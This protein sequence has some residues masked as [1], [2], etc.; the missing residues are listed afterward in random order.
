MECFDPVVIYIDEGD[1]AQALDYKVTR[2]VE[3][4]CPWVVIHSPEKSFERD[5]VMQVFAGMDSIAEI[6]AAFIENIENW[7]PASS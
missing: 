7:F 1:I 6:N 2:I 4:A 5:T 3:N